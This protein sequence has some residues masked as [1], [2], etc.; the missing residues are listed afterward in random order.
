MEEKAL[1]EE[2]IDAV[3][4]S[5]EAIAVITGVAASEVE[6]VASIGTSNIAKNWAEIIVGKKNSAK[7]V[8]IEIEENEVSIEMQITVKYGVSIPD[9]A[10]LVQENV[11]NA[12]EEMTGLNVKKVDVK[13]MGVKLEDK[14]AEKESDEKK[15]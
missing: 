3:K 13:V 8:K 6:G 9:V 14:K 15:D 5:D 1:V 11:K 4:I 12:V 10:R 7:G 2:K